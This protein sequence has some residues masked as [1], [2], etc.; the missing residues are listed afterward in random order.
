LAERGHR[1]T[2][3]EVAQ[4]LGPE[5][6][7]AGPEQLA[8]RLARC[9]AVLLD[10]DGVVGPGLKGP[11]APAAFN[12]IDAMGLNLL[13]Y[14]LWRRGES[15]AIP[16]LAVVSGQRDPGAQALAERDHLDA[17]YMG[18]LDKRPALE[19]LC[20]TRGLDAA[21]ILFVFD[22]V[23]DLGVAER[24]GAR[25]LVTRPAQPLVEAFARRRGLCDYLVRSPAGA[26]AVREACE[27][28]LAL[29][30]MDEEVFQARGW[31]EEGYQRYLEDRRKLLPVA[32]YVV[33][34]D[35]QT[36]QPVVREA[37]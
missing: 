18:F 10:W 33:E 32:R 8:A 37:R 6:F 26:G 1:Y 36:G 5:R 31:F 35:P 22:D 28:A 25:F 2:P 30:S 24:C 11:G 29:L 23:I 4:L 14:A 9:R 20:R 7:P 12:E 34:R 16:A 19:H 15:G 21:E 17:L 13:R 27:V 3:V